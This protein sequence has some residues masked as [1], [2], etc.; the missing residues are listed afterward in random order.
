V[1]TGGDT[2][3]FLTAD[4][5]F[6]HALEATPGV[7]EA[8]RQVSA[9][10]AIR[11]TAAIFPLL[12]QAQTSKAKVIGLA[13]AGAT[14]QL[15]QVGAESASSRAPKPAGLLCSQRRQRARPCAAQ[16]LT[17]T[18]PGIWDQNDTNR[19]W[20]NAGRR[21]VRSGKFR[22]GAGRRLCGRTHN[23]K[24][25]AARKTRPTASG[26]GQDE[27]TPTDRSAVRQ[28]HIRARPQDP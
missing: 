25:V 9:R 1:K 27:G 18:K 15:D 12:L 8:T 14:P 20:T 13:N 2:W 21:S 23:L 22:H 17:L 16:G 26:G 11:S 5:A 7:V 24:A 4:Y 10:C 19:A 28:G 6:G 3:F